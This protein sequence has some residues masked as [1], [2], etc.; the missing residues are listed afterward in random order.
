LAVIPEEARSW[1]RHCT[2]D[3]RCCL[4]SVEARRSR[5]CNRTG[6]FAVPYD[7]GGA[8]AHG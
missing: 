7:N 6:G 5:W 4:A 8:A 2:A 1:R 3:S